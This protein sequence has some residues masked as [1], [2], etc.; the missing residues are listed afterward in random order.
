M[1]LPEIKFTVILWYVKMGTNGEKTE[2]L[3][4]E[5]QSGEV[6]VIIQNIEHRDA[7]CAKL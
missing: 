7:D 1:G 5:T 4:G 3:K 6:T 2:N